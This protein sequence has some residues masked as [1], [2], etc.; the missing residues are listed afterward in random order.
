MYSF[1]AKISLI[2][3]RIGENKK[4]RSVPFRSVPTQRVIEN[5]KKRPRN[6]ENNNYRF[7]P[8]CS[9]PTRNR[10]FP[11]NRKKI[12]QYHFGIISSL[13]RFGKCRERENIKFTVPF[14]SYPKRN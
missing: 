2:K 11:K 4:H 10:K 8:F 5:S 14:R 3:W 1:Q 6:K 13:N 9:Y 12:Q 7:V